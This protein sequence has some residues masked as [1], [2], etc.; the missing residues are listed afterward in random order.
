MCVETNVIGLSVLADYVLAV[1]GRSCKKNQCADVGQDP[2]HRAKHRT[3]DRNN[4]S[5]V[6]KLLLLVRKRIECRNPV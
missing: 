4:V 3:K 1:S 5:I 6:I 2:T